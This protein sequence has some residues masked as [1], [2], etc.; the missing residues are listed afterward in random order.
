MV[1]CEVGSTVLPAQDAAPAASRPPLVVCIASD[2]I[3]GLSTALLV[4]PIVAII[5]K[6]IISNSS[7]RSRMMDGLSDGF[8]TLFRHPIRY[9]SKPSFI[10]VYCVFAG[11]YVT[12]NTVE[13]VCIHNHVAPTMPKFL[14][15]STVNVTLCA[16]KDALFAK[17]FATVA[18]KPMPRASYALFAI[19]DTLT[20][21]TSFVAPSIVSPMLQ[22]EPF[23]IQKRTADGICQLTLPCLVQFASAPL[24]LWSLDLYN[25]PKS[26]A[27]QRVQLIRGT[28]WACS[29]GRVF[30]TLPGFGLGGVANRH[31]RIRLNE[32]LWD[33][34]DRLQSLGLIKTA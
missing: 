32:F 8:G 6:S 5:D 2:V 12:N 22:D 24:H 15:G 27:M 11:T 25:N 3:A 33:K 7:G 4:A 13:T 19:R 29:L 1:I 20:V 23:R 28:Y 16:W 10:A 17:W 30:R 18:A 26:T 31:T 34:W 9:L 21:T 14:I